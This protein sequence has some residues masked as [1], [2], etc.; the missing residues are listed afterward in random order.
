MSETLRE[1]LSTCGLVSVEVGV[2]PD[3]GFP[4]SRPL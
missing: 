4:A 1:G 3:I 2:H